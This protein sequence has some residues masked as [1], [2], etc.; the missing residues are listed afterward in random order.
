MLTLEDCIALSGLTEEEIDAIAR[1]EHVPELVAAEIARYLAHAPNGA[2][3]VRRI[4]L[5]DLRDARARGDAA[6]TRRLEL[7]LRHFLAHHPHCRCAT[8]EEVAALL[9]APRTASKADRLRVRLNARA[10]TAGRRSGR[11]CPCG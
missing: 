3:V 5:D 11:R 8:E 4:I 9:A 2:P 7:T 6:E 10:G 1:H